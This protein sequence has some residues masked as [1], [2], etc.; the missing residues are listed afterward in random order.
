MII[1]EQVHEADLVALFRKRWVLMTLVGIIQIATVAVLLS[2]LPRDYVSTAE[3]EAGTS[4]VT[5]NYLET[6]RAIAEFFQLNQTSDAIRQELEKN[7]EKTPVSLRVKALGSQIK[8]DGIGKSPRQAQRIAEAGVKI[9]LDRHRILSAK[10][11]QSTSASF[12][13]IDKKLRE[14][15]KASLLAGKNK[16][17]DTGRDNLEQNMRDLEVAVYTIEYLRRSEA[18]QKDATFH[19][20]IITPPQLPG[21]PSIIQPL[22]ALSMATIIGMLCACIAAILADFFLKRPGP[23]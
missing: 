15:R 9:L 12:Q 3:V 8:I 6:P 13:E 10:E 18:M 17:N 7:G 16:K 21:K 14:A 19:T 2:V 22:I 5:G 20:A 4:P 11:E 1:L 23:F